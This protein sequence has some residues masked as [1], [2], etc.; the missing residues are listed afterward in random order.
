MNV[1]GKVATS[2]LVQP[3]AAPVGGWVEPLLTQ[4][5]VLDRRAALN[6]ALY[7]SFVAVD[8]GFAGSSFAFTNETRLKPRVIAA[9]TKASVV[10]ADTQDLRV[11][12]AAAGYGWFTNDWTLQATIGASDA[13]QVQVI[14]SRTIDDS[15]PNSN[16]LKESRSGL[17]RVLLEG[18]G[19]ITVSSSGFELENLVEPRLLSTGTLFFGDHLLPIPDA[20]HDGARIDLP[21]GSREPVQESITAGFIPPFL[22]P[23]GGMGVSLAGGRGFDS[24]YIE[25]SH[26]DDLVVLVLHIPE[27]GALSRQR[28]FR[29]ALVCLDRLAV[30][31]GQTSPDAASSIYSFIAT[32]TKD[33]LSSAKISQFLPAWTSNEPTGVMVL[34]SGSH[35]PLIA[36]IRTTNSALALDSFMS[37]AGA[38]VLPRERAWALGGDEATRAKNRHYTMR[39]ISQKVVDGIRQRV[40]RYGEYVPQPLEKQCFADDKVPWFW[41]VNGRYSQLDDGR[42][43][44]VISIA[45]LS[46]TGDIVC[47][48]QE[49]ARFLTAFEWQVKLSDPNAEFTTVGLV[50]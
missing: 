14:Q 40:F 31:L 6:L 44:A 41:Q 12:C 19:E 38:W 18:P 11:L 3:L 13:A 32:C 7:R 1:V 34:K 9:R 23:D 8:P 2:L 50:I 26:E 48:G 28:T 21:A 25:L 20:F 42:V 45:A 43:Q 46:R 47:Y 16:F 4:T 35:L 36:R 29:A 5:D 37:I 10:R 49:L 27:E 30:G 22:T 17:A 39:G 33:R 24:C 15:V